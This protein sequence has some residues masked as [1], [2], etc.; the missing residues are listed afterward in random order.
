MKFGYAVE[1]DATNMSIKCLKC[2]VKRYSTTHFFLDGLSCNLQDILEVL[3][4][5]FPQDLKQF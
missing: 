2:L 4:L 1:L 5:T 3:C